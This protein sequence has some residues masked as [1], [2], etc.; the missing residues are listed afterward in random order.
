MS[1]SP[2]TR[3]SSNDSEYPVWLNASRG[4]REIAE[5]KRIICE[6]G[7]EDAIQSSVNGS[8]VLDNLLNHVRC[9]EKEAT[10]LRAENVAW[11]N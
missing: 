9:L 6:A 10:A 2:I 5:F 3:E 8:E 11:K 4:F 7:Q 1:I